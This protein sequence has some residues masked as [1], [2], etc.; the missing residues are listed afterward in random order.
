MLGTKDFKTSQH[1]DMLPIC[2]DNF[3]ELFIL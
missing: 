1:P 3:H 2:K